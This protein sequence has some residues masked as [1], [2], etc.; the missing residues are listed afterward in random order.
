MSVLMMDIRRMW[1][2]VGDRLMEV[3]VAVA[4]SGHHIMGVRV[5]P[6]VVAVGMFMLHG[7]MRMLVPVALGQMQQHPRKHQNTTE[8]H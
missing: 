7:F 1:V 3:Q 6:V 2:G 5:V 4:T 8:Q